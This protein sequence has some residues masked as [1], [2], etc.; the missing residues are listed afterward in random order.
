MSVL[1]SRTDQNGVFVAQRRRFRVIV[2]TW[3]R[4]PK[5]TLEADRRIGQSEA[6]L[7]R[8]VH[9]T[10]Q[11]V[12]SKKKRQGSL[13]VQSDPS[14]RTTSRTH[15][16]TEKLLRLSQSKAFGASFGRSPRLHLRI[17]QSHPSDGSSFGRIFISTNHIL[18]PIIFRTD[19]RLDQSHPSA[20]SSFGRTFVLTNQNPSR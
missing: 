7:S 10:V 3:Q 4:S 8:Q 9:R 11:S 14:G 20:G 18:Q 12:A 2:F 1:A 15:H 6:F 13:L 16:H 17:G 19:F 5:K